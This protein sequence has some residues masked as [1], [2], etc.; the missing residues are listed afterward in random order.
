[1]A[2]FLDARGKKTSI[3]SGRKAE[4]LHIDKRHMLAKYNKKGLNPCLM[5]PNSTY[6]LCVLW[7]FHIIYNG[8]VL[9]GKRRRLRSWIVMICVQGTRIETKDNMLFMASFGNLFDN[10]IIIPFLISALFFFLTCCSNR[11]FSIASFCA[12]TSSSPPGH[13]AS[14][15]GCGMEAILLCFC[16]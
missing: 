10:P 15:A 14:G 8:K 1:M 11:I 7:L 13:A 12:D 9:L 6:F 3:F 2:V 4:H 5:L 16:F